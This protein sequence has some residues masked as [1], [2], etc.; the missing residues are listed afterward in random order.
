MVGVAE[1]LTLA[2]GFWVRTG[3]GVTGDFFITD[4]CLTGIL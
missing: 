3:V 4:A 1:M 2:F